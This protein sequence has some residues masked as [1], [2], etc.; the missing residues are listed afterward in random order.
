MGPSEAKVGRLFNAPIALLPVTLVG[1][2]PT[3][4][5]GDASSDEDELPAEYLFRG[6]LCTLDCEEV[7]VPLCL[8]KPGVMDLL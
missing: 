8:V 5:G 6:G 2:D 3:A 1:D 7:P 4:T